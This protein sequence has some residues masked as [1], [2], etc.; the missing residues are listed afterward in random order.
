MDDWDSDSEERVMPATTEKL[1][2]GVSPHHPQVSTEDRAVSLAKNIKGALANYLGGRKLVRVKIRQVEGSKIEGFL[3]I[4]G[5]KGER[6][7][8]DFKAVSAPHGGLSSL[9]VG[10]KKVSLELG[11]E[12]RRAH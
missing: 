10:G 5:R 2:V 8:V 3:K 7:L 6:L 12:A 9:V 1:S 4:E 11:I